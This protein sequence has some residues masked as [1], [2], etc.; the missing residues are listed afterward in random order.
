MHTLAF[1][2]TEVTESE[3]P[4]SHRFVTWPVPAFHRYT[5]LPRPE[6]SLLLYYFIILLFHYFITITS[7]ITIYSVLRLRT[8]GEYVLHGPMNEVEIKIVLD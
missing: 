3:G 8:D 4:K 5:Q 2:L 6:P 1:Q 7:T